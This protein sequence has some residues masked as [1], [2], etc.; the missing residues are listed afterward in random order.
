M[1]AEKWGFEEFPAIL[2]KL[3]VWYD[4][5]K[6]KEIAV[7]FTAKELCILTSV[8]LALNYILTKEGE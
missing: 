6:D 3:D 7:K 1:A 5:P 4:K 2:K 8:V